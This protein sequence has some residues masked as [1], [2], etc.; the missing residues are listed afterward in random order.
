MPRA[1]PNR[2]TGS[3]AAPKL[4]SLV[5]KR[6]SRS[7]MACRV[8]RGFSVEVTAAAGAAADAVV[9]GAAAVGLGSWAHAG[10]RDSANNTAA[11][12]ISILH[13]PRAADRNWPIPGRSWRVS[14]RGRIHW[15]PTEVA[16]GR[17]RD[18]PSVVWSSR[19]GGHPPGPRLWRPRCRCGIEFQCR[20]WRP[21]LLAEGRA[22]RRSAAPPGAARRPESRWKAWPP[23]RRPAARWIPTTDRKSTRLNSSHLG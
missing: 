11:D 9:A 14:G 13:C 22:E 19:S 1:A 6:L 23:R 18:R 7:E 21:A 3:L 20:R 10:A 15:P 16:A 17:L 2:S 5:S 4:E 12:F 8:T